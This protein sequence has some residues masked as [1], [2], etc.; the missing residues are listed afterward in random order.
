MSHAPSNGGNGR[1][2]SVVLS[3]RH[4]VSGVVMPEFRPLGEQTA[5]QE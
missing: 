4:G 5:T 2:S 1:V 3:E